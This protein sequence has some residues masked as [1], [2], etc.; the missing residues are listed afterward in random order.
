MT[1]RQTK[2][3]VFLTGKESYIKLSDIAKSIPEYG[4]FK[5]DYHNSTARIN[6][7]D[8]IRAINDSMEFDGIILSDR[9]GIKLASKSDCEQ[10]LRAELISVLKALK[11]VKQKYAKYNLDGQGFIT[12]DMKQDFREVFSN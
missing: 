2:L 8:D 3:I 10:K 12:D 1:E 6:M 4:S 11:R 9:N 5:D 7:T